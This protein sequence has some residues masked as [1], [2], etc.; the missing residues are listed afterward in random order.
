VFLRELISNANDALEKLRL[1]AL[2]EK[3]IWDGVSPLNLTI[4][5]EKNPDGEGGRIIITG[6]C[7]FASWFVAVLTVVPRYRHWHE[8]SGINNQPGMGLVILRSVSVTEHFEIIRVL[9]RS[10][11]PLTFLRE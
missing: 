2:T 5:A 4:K 9:W 8:C 7:H 6:L 3:S 10:L 1:T 11:E